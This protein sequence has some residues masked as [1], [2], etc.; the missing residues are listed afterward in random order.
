L[1]GAVL[2]IAGNGLLQAQVALQGTSLSASTTNLG[3]F[4]I[5]DIP[6]GTYT[7]TAA[8]GARLSGR[9][10]G[11][12]IEGGKVATV[13]IVVAT[14]SPGGLRG[15]VTAGGAAVAGADVSLVLSVDPNNPVKDVIYRT[16]T[17]ADGTFSLSDL[18]ASSAYTLSVVA[19]GYKPD[20][21]PVTVSAG[22]I[23]PPI[24][25][26]LTTSQGSKPAAPTNL[27]IQAWTYPRSQ[28][29]QQEAYR[30]L[31]WH[32]TRTYFPRFTAM[33]QAEW[34]RPRTRSD[35]SSFVE[36]DLVW[37]P[38]PGADVAG[39]RIYRGTTEGGV[40]RIAELPDP[41][42]TGFID[43]DPTLKVGT[44][45][46]YRVTAYSVGGQESDRS[47]TVSAAPLPQVSL[48]LPFNGSAGIQSNP[49][50]Q[51]NAVFIAKSY[52]VEI[53]DAFPEFG[54]NPIWIS[55]PVTAGTGTFYNGVPL[56]GG[57]TFYWA[58]GAHDN[59]DPF[60]ATATSVSEIWHFTVKQ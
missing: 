51:W 38:V 29:R 8:K 13:Q 46:Y 48:L 30:A 50:L 9:V 19:S 20:I 23:S 32:L 16:A 15:K 42:R 41:N 54:D 1:I 27:A 55:Q 45:Y 25:I 17:A 26:S 58:T 12:K 37:D 56:A 33:P 24:N 4:E 14:G 47:A 7:V 35:E 49:F 6:P 31:K 21:R 57:Q 44:Y 11:V 53:Y 34:A 36:I 52:T 22:V 59:V 2:D 28:T 39:Y 5:S 60:Q 18:P 10:S 40:T 3:T 43:Y